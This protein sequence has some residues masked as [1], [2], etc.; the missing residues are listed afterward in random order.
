MFNQVEF[1]VS[2]YLKLGIILNFLL[3]IKEVQYINSKTLFKLRS[4]LKALY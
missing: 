3:T 4:N 2:P 1:K